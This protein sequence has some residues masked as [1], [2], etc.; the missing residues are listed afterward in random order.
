MPPL[1]SFVSSNS[2]RRRRES[3]Q[4]IA[5]FRNAVEESIEHNNEI[6][7]DTMA[8]LAEIDMEKVD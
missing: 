6:Y 1:I 4:I 7:K 3:I 8:R 5:D 2:L